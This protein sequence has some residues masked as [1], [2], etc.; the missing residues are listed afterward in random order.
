MTTK[1]TSIL[2]WNNKISESIRR[3]KCAFLIGPGVLE[4]SG[5]PEFS[6]IVQYCI[7]LLQNNKTKPK[8]LDWLTKYK[9]KSATS[10]PLINTEIPF[11][12]FLEILALGSN[13]QPILEIFRKAEPN[14]YHLFISELAKSGLLP[15]VV[16]TNIDTCLEKAFQQQKVAFHVATNPE[17][18][19][20]SA[21]QTN[22][23]IKINGCSSNIDSIKTYLEH[24]SAGKSSEFSRELL[25]NL[26]ASGEHDMIM[27]LGFNAE[28]SYELALLLNTIKP[29][30]KTIVFVE[31]SK[32]MKAPEIESIG[33]NKI[34]NPF[35]KFKG[36]RYFIDGEVF[37]QQLS[38]EISSK[39]KINHQSLTVKSMTNWQHLLKQWYSKESHKS[40]FL[41]G[42]LY[43]HSLEFEKAFELLH[44]EESKNTSYQNQLLALLGTIRL[45][46]YNFSEAEKYF[47]KS[48]NSVG[49]NDDILAFKC[50]IGLADIKYLKKC[51]HE[52]NEIYNN[53]LSIALNHNWKKHVAHSL[54]GKGNCQT[55]LLFFENALELEN[56]A[57]QIF[58]EIVDN[59]G[60]GICYTNIANI[61]QEQLKFNEAI[62]FYEKAVRLLEPLRNIEEL[63]KAYVGIGMA[64]RNYDIFLNEIGIFDFDNSRII[65]AI[66]YLDKAV[67]I[68]LTNN[69]YTPLYETYEFL[70]LIYHELGREKKSKTYEQRKQKIDS[71]MLNQ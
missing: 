70:S 1:K 16:T 58:R 17:E 41:L 7:Q 14:P 6:D 15:L 10:Y 39:Q 51:F 25:E 33:L 57:L 63:G 71:I 5:V 54:V 42:S 34:D 23:I 38:L 56:Q 32:N 26:F 24:S 3:K 43:L 12:K 27:V 31:H 48:F 53:A 18:I 55:S 60:I 22:P 66:N 4:N 61:Y 64:Y 20:I 40:N 37:V 9:I 35:S 67:D 50:L 49:K 59:T 30:N 2:F 47:S 45:K 19:D 11:N 52:A 68:Y 65:K 36:I 8:V 29:G 21:I 13:I 44:L 69:L 28:N 46:Q 62:E